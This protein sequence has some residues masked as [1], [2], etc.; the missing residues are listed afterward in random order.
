MRWTPAVTAFV[1]GQLMGAFDTDPQVFLSGGCDA[2]NRQLYERKGSRIFNVYDNATFTCPATLR[3]EY[4]C[5][6]QGQ[7]LRVNNQFVFYLIV[8]TPIVTSDGTP[9]NNPIGTITFDWEVV[10][11]KPRL[12]AP[13]LKTYN[14]YTEG[15]A[16]DGSQG[17]TPVVYF[18]RDQGDIP[19]TSSGMVIFRSLGAGIVGLERGAQYAWRKQGTSSSSITFEFLV[20]AKLTGAQRNDDADLITIDL[21]VG[22]DVSFIAQLIPLGPDVGTGNVTP[23]SEVVMMKSNASFSGAVDAIGDIATPGYTTTGFTGRIVGATNFTNDSTPEQQGAIATYLDSEGES[24]PLGERDLVEYFRVPPTKLAKALGCE[25]SELDRIIGCDVSQKAFVG[26]LI[27]A[28]GLAIR[29][30]TASASIAKVAIQIKN[31]VSNADTAL[32]KYAKAHKANLGKKVRT[33]VRFN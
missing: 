6:A 5:D 24:Q 4:N 7:D 8:T 19:T 23:D 11:M 17:N 16:K 30:L 13:T 22:E 9:F 27:T 25:L 18:T 26:V 28:L 29:I 20:Y 12:I 14:S 32:A 33:R 21:T 3:P 15:S 31:T 2:V 10:F 1:G